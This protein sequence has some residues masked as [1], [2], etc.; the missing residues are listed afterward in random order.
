MAKLLAVFNILAGAASLIGL[1]VQYTS[2]SSNWP[3]AIL[4]P[5]YLVT[6]VLCIYVLFVPGNSIEK[7]VRSKV[8]LYRDKGETTF[9]GNVMIQ[10]GTVTFFG[11]KATIEFERP[12][13]G[14]PEVTIINNKERGFA[15]PN[16]QLVSVNGQVAVF[17]QVYSHNLLP[18]RY[19]WVARGEPLYK[20]N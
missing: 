18:T 8:E 1:V 9:E 6:L 13:K 4:L 20:V 17:R 19:K 11:G 2:S 14:K 16:I 7:N 3:T 10:R 5:L 15:G 12:F